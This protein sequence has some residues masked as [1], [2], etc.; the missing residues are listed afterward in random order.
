MTCLELMQ[1]FFASHSEEH[2]VSNLHKGTLIRIV[3]VINQIFHE[4]NLEKCDGGF[5]RKFS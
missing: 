4:R 1:G 5:I 2:P 3:Y